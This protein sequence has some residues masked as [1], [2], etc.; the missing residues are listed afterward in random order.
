MQKIKDIFIANTAEAFA[1]LLE[2]AVSD[3]NHQQDRCQQELDLSQR[4]QFWGGDD[5]I[6]ITP[7]PIPDALL[8]H[9][10]K[11]VGYKNIINLWPKQSGLRL[12]KS[13]IDDAILTDHL[14][15]IIRTNPGVRLSS[16]A[17]TDNYTHLLKVLGKRVD[18]WRATNM[19]CVAN[20]TNLV[21]TIDSKIGFRE[22]VADLFPR[23]N[24]M[25]PHGFI[26]K[27][28]P[29]IF[30]AIFSFLNAGRGFVIKVHN[31]ESGWGVKIVDNDT[32]QRLKQTKVN[33]WLRE[34]FE[35]DPVWKFAPYVVEEFIPV[36]KT[37]GGGFPSGEGHITDQ[38]FIFDYDCGQEVTNEGSFEG[39]VINAGILP[40]S[41]SKNIKIAM[42][43]IGKKF[44][45]NGYRGIFDVDFAAGLDG[46]LYILESNSR[47]TGGTH[48][49]NI[50][51]YLGFNGSNAYVL[52]ND[53]FRYNAPVQK[54]DKILALLSDVIYP[55]NHQKRGLILSF[56]STGRPVIGIIAVGK[57]REDV[58]S[59][60]HRA[61][62]CLSAY[63]C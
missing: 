32:A 33:E 4:A 61:K 49:Y 17:A 52:S 6:I 18:K 53:S 45:T 5:K 46:N 26:C 54:P 57:N 59:L 36:D 27:T 9:N 19:P 24:L 39:V 3:N 28:E 12:C 50:I 31:G 55:I 48:V 14:I 63:K 40:N 51:S 10:S 23:K 58:R 35:S 8:E 44:Y 56:I 34:L 11:S 29:D 22:I 43:M 16:Y 47:M 60:I 37:I 38:R 20:P 42:E 1:D 41:A 7:E 25:L 2:R 30:K 15:E 13:I 21:E 62:D